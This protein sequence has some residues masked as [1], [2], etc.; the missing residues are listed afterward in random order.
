[1]HKVFVRTS[2]AWFDGA[3]ASGIPA[4]MRF[5]KLNEKRIDGLIAHVSHPISIG[6]L[7]GFSNRIKVDKRIDYG[8]RDEGYF[9]SLI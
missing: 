5:A 1:M 3:K 7:E 4:L 8:Y 6:K 9:F 2:T